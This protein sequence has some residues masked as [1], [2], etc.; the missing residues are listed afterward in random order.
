MTKPEPRH[1]ATSAQ[2]ANAAPLRGLYAITPEDYLLP[3]L[4]AV[5]GAA[6]AGGDG[7]GAALVAGAVADAHVDRGGHAGFGHEGLRLLG[8]GGVEAAVV[9]DADD[10]VVVVLERE[11]LAGVHQHRVG[12]D[13]RDEGVDDLLPG[14][15]VGEG[16]AQRQAGVGVAEHVV[17]AV[18]EVEV[19][20]RQRR[21]GLDGHGGAEALELADGVDGGLRLDD[22]DVLVAECLDLLRVVDESEDE[23]LLLFFL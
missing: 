20:P 14:H 6:L 12:R 16:R 22:L 9:G 23:V 17:L 8:I 5:V 15:A 13:G 3:R 19:L 7:L 11:D 21:A 4:S 10:L 2:P 18:V 1:P